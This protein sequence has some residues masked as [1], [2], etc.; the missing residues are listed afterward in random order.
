[1]NCQMGVGSGHIITL[2]SAHHQPACPE[3]HFACNDIFHT[4]LPKRWICDGMAEC[5]NAADEANCTASTV[6]CG[7]DFRCANLQCIPGI[8]RCD[9]IF[10]CDDNT[11]EQNCTAFK[12]ALT[13]AG[14]CNKEHGK[15]QCSTGECLD[16]ALVCDGRSDCL[17]GDD[18]HA[19]QCRSRSSDEAGAA[20]DACHARQCSHMCLF[21][22][23]NNASFCYCPPGYHLEGG[24]NGTACTDYDE[25]SDV[26]LT[27]LCTQRCTNL[28]GGYRC[29]CYDGY[30]M[31]NVS[32]AHGTTTSS[33]LA[34]GTAP[35]LYYSTGRAIRAVDLRAGTLV[36]IVESTDPKEIIVG[37]DIEVANAHQRLLFFG[38]TVHSHGTVYEVALAEGGLAHQL[39]NGHST[40][41]YHEALKGIEGLAV[42]WLAGH[43]YIAE[44]DQDRIL[45]CNLE[46]KPAHHCTTLL[47]NL[48]QPR[49]I[50][51]L[52]NKGRLF[53]TQWGAGKA[54]IYTAAMDGAG[55]AL[56]LDKVHWPNGLAMDETLNRLYWCDG[57]E[58][59][60][61]YYDFD[62]HVR[63]LVFQDHNRQPYAL[64]VF[65]DSLYFSDWATNQIEV[66][67]K[68]T[69]H[70]MRPLVADAKIDRFFGLAVYHPLMHR[71][72][73]RL[74]PFDKFNPCEKAPCTHLCLLKQGALGYSCRCPD[75]MTL[76]PK[77]NATCVSN[78]TSAITVLPA[79]PVPAP[80]QKT[81]VIKPSATFAPIIIAPKPTTT[82][83]TTTTTT[84]PTTT[85]TTTVEP[86]V[87]VRMKE[88]D[89]GIRP[90]QSAENML[91]EQ[92]ESARPSDGSSLTRTLCRL[93]IYCIIL[94]I[95][96]FVVLM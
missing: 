96:A 12:S 74:S 52:P 2:D 71:A 69:G 67:D 85:T 84:S 28:E 73:G 75:Q 78:S 89:N 50:L 60:I 22:P 65:E 48:S 40:V 66:C 59:T 27:N 47:A 64:A 29:D 79:K 11:D 82:T 34:E 92:A 90:P 35:L 43:F 72:S 57:K 87:E 16:Y 4:C 13:G 76:S 20:S 31:T 10:D 86:A 18:E 14:A 94:A 49:A 5:A 42:D 26:K 24:L 83:T 56:F 91:I 21:D 68:I 80:P 1:M 70:H 25:C 32:G 8:W 63:H 95:V 39:Q 33:C 45:V 55:A 37:M 61:E 30:R 44:S 36:P 15:F 6:D 23:V 81:V 77:D 7:D 58:G 54:G 17:L 19:E 62:T 88:E 46:A 41:L 93:L 3:D 38:S 51:T 53:W 9:G